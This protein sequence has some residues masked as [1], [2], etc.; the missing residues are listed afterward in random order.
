MFVRVCVRVWEG[1]GGVR[2]WDVRGWVG[3]VCGVCV[4]VVCVGCVCGWCGL[5]RK[6][7]AEG[8]GGGTYETE[9][10]ILFFRGGIKLSLKP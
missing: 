3:G 1:V 6:G 5:M 2:V 10:G 4:W 9:R 7:N 8:G